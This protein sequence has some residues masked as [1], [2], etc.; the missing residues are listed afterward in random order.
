MASKEQ[1]FTSKYASGPE[2]DEKPSIL[3]KSIQKP[4][5][6]FFRRSERLTHLFELV[7]DL[8]QLITK[9]LRS[10]RQRCVRPVDDVGATRRTDGDE[11]FRLE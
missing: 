6:G 4:R 8:G 3:H 5:N 1:G 7:T 10:A 2:C 9:L 11:T